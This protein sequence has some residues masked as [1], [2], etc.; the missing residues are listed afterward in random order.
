M[1]ANERPDAAATP[2]VDRRRRTLRIAALVGAP[3]LAI[4]IALWATRAAS[5]SPSRR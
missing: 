5:A 3:L 4:G 1:T 2:P